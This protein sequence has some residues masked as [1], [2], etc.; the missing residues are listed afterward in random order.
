MH[1]LKSTAEQGLGNGGHGRPLNYVCPRRPRFWRKSRHKRVEESGNI[2]IVLKIHSKK[3]IVI[4]ISLHGKKLNGY[5]MLLTRVPHCLIA[6]LPVHDDQAQRAATATSAAVRWCKSVRGQRKIGRRMH[7]AFLTFHTL[8][9]AGWRAGMHASCMGSKGFRSPTNKSRGG[10]FVCCITPRPSPRV[11][12][13]V[14][15]V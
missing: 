11:F 5:Y 9:A 8:H 3:K 15:R 14:F 7:W 4:S 1:C 13:L 12:F 10:A 2:Q 6:N